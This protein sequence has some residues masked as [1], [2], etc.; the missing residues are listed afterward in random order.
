[1]IKDSHNYKILVVFGLSAKLCAITSHHFDL[2]LIIMKLWA[3]I[4]YV[5]AFCLYILVHLS[6][7]VTSLFNC[8]TSKHST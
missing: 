6:H 1:M 5:Y 8:S 7:L 4:F 2:S 3:T